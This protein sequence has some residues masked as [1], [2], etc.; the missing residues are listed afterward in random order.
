MVIFPKIIVLFV[1]ITK[2]D[3]F[4]TFDCNRALHLSRIDNWYTIII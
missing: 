1:L 3:N 4:I 2:K